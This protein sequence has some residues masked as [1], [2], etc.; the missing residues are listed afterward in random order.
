M[1]S[2]ISVERGRGRRVFIT[3]E[4]TD[5]NRTIPFTRVPFVV[6]PSEAG[7][8]AQARVLARRLQRDL[9]ANRGATPPADRQFD[10]RRILLEELNG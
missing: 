4:W 6:P 10:L 9:D 1:W 7:L 5:G 2:F 8:R 3:V